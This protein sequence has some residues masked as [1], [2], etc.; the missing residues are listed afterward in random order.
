MAVKLIHSGFDFC[1]QQ[2]ESLMALGE[3]SWA[4]IGEMPVQIC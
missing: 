2:C 3:A 4:K 1:C